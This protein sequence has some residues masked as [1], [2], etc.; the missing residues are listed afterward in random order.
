MF[1]W[2]CYFLPHLQYTFIFELF[3]TLAFRLLLQFLVSNFTNLGFKKMFTG[4]K[5]I[6]GNKGVRGESG[7][8]GNKG[9]KVMFII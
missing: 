9:D 3:K 8:K 6:Q 5:G 4:V 1:Y 2:T 7:T